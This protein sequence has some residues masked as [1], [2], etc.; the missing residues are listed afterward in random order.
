MKHV[1][2]YF[3]IF[4]LSLRSESFQDKNIDHVEYESISS[5]KRGYKS[6]RS[7]DLYLKKISERYDFVNY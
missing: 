3:F 7:N 6:Y 4:I 2:L 5:L 1:I